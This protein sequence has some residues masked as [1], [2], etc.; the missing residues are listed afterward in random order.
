MRDIFILS[1]VFTL[2]GLISGCSDSG[3]SNML[4]SPI[5]EPTPK[6]TVPE[7]Y[8]PIPI[9]VELE[10]E[11]LVQNLEQGMLNQLNTNSPF[12]VKTLTNF[13]KLI[14]KGVSEDKKYVLTEEN[15]SNTANGFIT[16][17]K[18]NLLVKL[19]RSGNRTHD[20]SPTYSIFTKT[21]FPGISNE[22]KMELAARIEGLEAA[23]ATALQD[24]LR[25]KG[26]KSYALT[27]REQLELLSKALNA[28]VSER[29]GLDLID[30]IPS[31][32]IRHFQRAHPAFTQL[33]VDAGSH[34][35]NCFML[36]GSFIGIINTHII[37][38][39][40]TNTFI[41]SLN[42]TRW[43][44]EGR[45]RDSPRLSADQ[46][47][48]HIGYDFK[49]TTLSINYYEWPHVGNIHTVSLE[50]FNT[51]YHL[52]LMNISC[53]ISTNLGYTHHYCSEKNDIYQDLSSSFVIEHQNG[54]KASVSLSLSPILCSCCFYVNFEL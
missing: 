28:N 8:S 29:L 25:L 18:Q 42:G 27:A 26:S 35:L 16:L 39:H 4:P 2:S 46:R 34:Q 47:C 7:P 33:A 23:I 43:F 22:M 49:N 36:P 12:Q 45:F 3:K 53:N 19:P 54:I 5:S 41:A 30:H 14:I 31:R 9:K 17:L 1:I 40:K 15:L 11:K 50:Y 6:E 44:L 24:L 10:T 13:S 37:S 32:S 21:N 48:A 38:K 52:D 51:V 20:L